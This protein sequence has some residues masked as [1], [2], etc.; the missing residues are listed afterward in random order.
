[1]VATNGT[2]NVFT[3]LAP[4]TYTFRVTDSKGCSYEESFT[5]ET[6]SVITVT[7]QSI[8]NIG[9]FAAS[10]GE[11][12]FTV[13]NFNT[14]FNYSISGPANFN[15][16]SQTDGSIPLDGLAAGTYTITVTDNLTGC[17]DT[18]D[19]TI[20]SPTAALTATHS[21]TQP[22]CEAVGAVNISAQDGWG[23]YTYEITSG[24]SGYTL[25][26]SNGNGQ[27]S[28]LTLEG[29]YTYTVTDANGCE[30]I[31]NFEVV[32]AVPPVLEIDANDICYDDAVGLTL[33]AN[34][35]SGGDGNYEYSLNGGPFQD[36]PEFSDL[37]PGTYTIE[38]RDGNDCTDDA[39]IT[40][41]PELSLVASAPNISSCD[42]ETLVS[43][44]AAGGDGNYV[45][46]IVA[47]NATPNGTAFSSTNP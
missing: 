7:G 4:D 9:C 41:D 40:I 45:Y 1:S 15:A 6:V 42:D 31:N 13:S 10:D 8:S 18:A 28:N 32:A 25:P 46:E 33:T 2:N 47:N 12:S 38:V 43:I 16:T 37:G 30:F 17:V 24:P 20:E 39:T 14:D 21:L 23:S 5:L 22:T 19:V 35:T 44:T 3:D 27:F 26:P 34:V 29:N 36:S 11:A